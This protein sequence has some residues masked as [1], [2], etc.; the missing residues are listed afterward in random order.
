[1]LKAGWFAHA[2]RSEALRDYAITRSQSLGAAQQTWRVRNGTA[3]VDTPVHVAFAALPDLPGKI[4]RILGEH[5]TLALRLSAE[6]QHSYWQLPWLDDFEIEVLLEIGHL[7]VAGQRQDIAE[8][9]LASCHA[10]AGPALLALARQLH[11][12]TSLFLLPEP[13]VHTALR[14]VFDSTAMPIKYTAPHA[15]RRRS[16]VNLC[17][18]NLTAIVEHWL[19]NQAGVRQQSD[20]E[21]V[22]QLRVALRRLNAACKLFAPW[23]DPVWRERLAPELRWLRGLLGRT[24]DWDVFVDVTLP[25]LCAATLPGSKAN[26]FS[27]AR[28]Q[29]NEARTALQAAM[30]S[31]RYATLLLDIVQWLTSLSQQQAVDGRLRGLRK[32]VKKWLRKNHLSARS[33]PHFT[34]LTEAE[35]HRIRLRAKRLRYSMEL[36]APLL[37]AKSC[38]SASRGYVTMLDALGAAN[39]AAVAAELIK[40]LPLHAETRAYANGWLAARRQHCIGVVERQLPHLK[41]PALR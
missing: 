11:Q 3:H 26:E 38:R 7:D 20:I 6:V 39:D 28:Q 33:I 15:F 14:R 17:V 21:Y 29:R 2:R 27:Q 35:Q 8:L 25:G 18:A 16:S 13:A 9:T 5:S 23:L 31:T 24:R 10:N 36:L 37:S 40:Q 34:R 22:H 41:R 32:H 12:T 19:S 30:E 1:L 4:Q